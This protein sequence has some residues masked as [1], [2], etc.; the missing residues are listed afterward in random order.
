MRIVASTGRS[1]SSIDGALQRYGLSLMSRMV[2][3][4][5]VIVDSIDKAPTEN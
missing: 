5:I 4:E 3:I 1:M 2:S